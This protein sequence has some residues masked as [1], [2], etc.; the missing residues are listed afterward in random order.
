MLHGF[1]VDRALQL[2]VV[3]VGELVQGDQPRPQRGEPGVGLP[4]AELRGDPAS[5]VTRSERSCPAVSPATWDHASA[6]GTLS[7]RRP[8]TATSSTSQSTFPPSGM[9]TVV[10]GPDNAVRNLVNVGGNVSGSGCRGVG[11]VVRCDGEH[12]RRGGG[13]RPEIDGIETHR[14]GIAVVLSISVAQARN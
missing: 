11:V 9:T 12:L 7:A 13:G 2:D 4:K 8:I 1:P 14:I 5:W 3:R 6:A 10:T